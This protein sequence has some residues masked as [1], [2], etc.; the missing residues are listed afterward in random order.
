ME[1]EDPRDYRVSFEKIRSV[2]G[3]APRYELAEGID[4]VSELFRN[5][6]ISDPDSPQ[7]GN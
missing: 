4:E 6:L 1:G 2:L 5:E 7:Y 3:F